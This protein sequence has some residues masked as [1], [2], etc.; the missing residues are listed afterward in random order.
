MAAARQPPPCL[1]QTHY[2][3][4]SGKSSMSCKLSAGSFSSKKFS[5]KSLVSDECK[6][7]SSSFGALKTVSMW[8]S[9]SPCKPAKAGKL[10]DEARI[11]MAVTFFMILSVNVSGGKQ[12]FC[13]GS[14]LSI[15]FINIRNFDSSP[16][17]MT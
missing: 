3:L 11:A 1:Q 5:G 14:I 8:K 6:G 4:F 7:T 16:N 13:L 12:C 17:F 9:T 2:L 15:P 10:K